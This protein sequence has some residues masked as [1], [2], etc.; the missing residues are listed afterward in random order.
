MKMLEIKGIDSGYGDVTVLKNVSLNIEEGEVVSIVGANG[1]GKTT[2]LNTISGILN[3]KKGEIWLDEQRIDR[4]PPHKIT[5]LGIVQVPEGRRIFPLMTVLENLL[6]G[7]SLPRAKSKQKENMEYVFELLPRLAERK[8]QIGRTMSGGEQ[9]MLAIG[10]ALMANP[11]LLMLDE[12]S[13][14][15][16][17]LLVSTVFDV[18]KKIGEQN[19]TVLLVEQNV[20]KA[21]G[22]S[23]R[24]YVL[25]NG[26][27][28]MQGPSA[29]LL[30]NPH[31][32]KAYLGL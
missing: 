20:K 4:L 29:D 24:G 27:I 6:I 5:E 23:Q 12:P 15:L 3:A 18:I 2:L 30:N 19:I 31:I 7:A 16:S 17:P 1:A 9:Q 25:E 28:S 22:L 21:L 13:M 10:R 8:N 26:F 32:K 11:R 14:G